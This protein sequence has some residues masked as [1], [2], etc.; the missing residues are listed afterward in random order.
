MTTIVMPAPTKERTVIAARREKAISCVPPQ[1]Q[2]LK[3][4]G[5]KSITEY[6]LWCLRYG[7]EDGMPRRALERRAPTQTDNDQQIAPHHTPERRKDI[8]ERFTEGT[9]PFDADHFV[10]L[11]DDAPAREALLRLLLHVDLYM[12]ATNTRRVF[13][14]IGRH[15][16]VHGLAALAYHHRR[17]IRPLEDW[18]SVLPKNGTPRPSDQFS[19][20]ARHLLARYEVPS[21][22]DTAFF[23]GITD[24][25]LEQQEWFIHI[26]NG[27]N[28][29]DLDTP[30]KMT[31]RMAHLF[32]NTPNRDSLEHN[33]RWAQVIGMG[34]NSTLAKAIL[35][36]R[37][38]R[39]S[40]NDEFW[41][42]VVLFL[43]NNAMLDPS[44]ASPMIDY[45]HNMKFAPRRI[46]QEGG[47]VEEAPPAQ[48]NF[49]MKGRSPAKLLRQVD[50]WHGHLNREQHVEFQSWQPS[51]IRAWQMEEETDELGPVRWTVQELLS[52]WELAA[53]GRAMSHC[54]VSYSDQCADGQTAIWSICMQRTGRE[55]RE[56]VLTVAVDIKSNTVTQSRGRYNMQPNKLPSNHRAQQAAQNGYFPMINRS[57]FV[58]R[59]WIGRERL[60]RAD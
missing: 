24:K 55:E 32:L 41:S 35:G 42:T 22:M 14:G 36:T 7:L 48:A 6:R 39:H 51:G 50:E 15:N 44:W 3:E 8:S 20:I 23:L 40:N 31:K 11:R 13:K 17:W 5:F 53:E 56:H 60:R 1:P 46:V 18:S 37:L 58:L 34:G 10:W 47:G 52:S 30:I 54:V 12:N 45:V 21:F 49:T 38:G 19:S 28:I 59:E 26:G 2:H 29:R 16:I 33:M 9:Y 43:V 25:G 27:G 4:L 57:A